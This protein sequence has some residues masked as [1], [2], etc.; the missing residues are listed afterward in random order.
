MFHALQEQGVEDCLL[1]RIGCY[2][3]EAPAVCYGPIRQA[4]EELS[5]VHLVSTA[6]AGMKAR[7]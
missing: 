4:Q 1:I 6:F 5:H 7:G 3:G 2:N